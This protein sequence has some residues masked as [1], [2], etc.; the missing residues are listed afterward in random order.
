M[1]KIREELLGR[2]RY[3]MYQKESGSVWIKCMDMHIPKYT[4]WLGPYD[5]ESA[6]SFLDSR[7]ER[8]EEQEPRL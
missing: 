2:Y 6:H 7:I 3:S 4:M 8:W 1:N 5:R